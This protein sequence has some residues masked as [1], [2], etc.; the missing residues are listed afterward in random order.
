MSLPH[1]LPRIL[2]VSSEASPWAKS[3]GLADVLGALP[4]A[5][6]ALG[7]PVAVVVPAYG[8]VS[9]NLDAAG[10]D[11]VIDRL[12]IPLGWPGRNISTDISIRTLQIGNVTMYF[13][14]NPGLYGREG[15][16]GDSSGDFPD[17]HIRFAV[18]CKAALEISRRLFAADVIHCHDWQ[19]SLVPLYMKNAGF[20]DPH[21]L[22]IR[23]L[24]TIH[25]LGYQGIFGQ[26][27]LADIGV[28]ESA[29]TPAGIEFWG[30]VNYLKAGIVFAD[31]LTTVSP[32]YAEEIQTPEYGFGL[33]GLLTDRRADLT[34][35]INGVD[36]ERWNPAS[37]PA[38][39][40]PFSA[41]NL[42]GKRA[43]KQALLQEMG[44]PAAAIDRPLLGIVSR[45]AGQKGFDLLGEIAPELF[46]RDVC[47]VALGNGERQ[48]EELF[49]ALQSQFPGQVGLRLG[50]DDGLAHRIE[51]GADIFLMPSRYEPC[52]L[53]QIYSL[54]YGTVPVVRATGGLDDTIADTI[55]DPG[56]DSTADEGTGFKFRDYNGEALLEAIGRACR[57]WE[58]RKTWTAMMVRGMQRDFSWTASAREYSS[59]YSRLVSQP[60]ASSVASF[61]ASL[62]SQGNPDDSNISSEE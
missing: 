41:R 5:L 32:K 34:G 40:A 58:D 11:R 62:A 38:I 7:H 27:S 46:R 57:A 48:Y 15:L 16:Y 6:G 49:Q 33:D 56:M 26:S 54:R 3:G 47:L 20:V 1:I 36:Y 35:I 43:C 8:T 18:L 50:Y 29:F 60:S 31:A 21:F 9:R 39:A 30:Q 23:T 53:N 55:T 14:E 17:N 13:V 4:E 24:L 10:A 2:M 45:F 22:G 19:A 59:L 61:A 42:A 12:R 37:D 28:P 25:N 44:L 51:A 52:G